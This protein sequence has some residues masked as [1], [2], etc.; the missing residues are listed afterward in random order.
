MSLI[1]TI[2]LSGLV[3]DIGMEQ[4]DDGQ[5]TPLFKVSHL[6]YRRSTW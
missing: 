5:M 3:Q 1:V 4:T 2:A 6:L